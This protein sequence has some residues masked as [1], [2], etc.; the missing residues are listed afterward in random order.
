M[1][2]VSV[3]HR[4]KERTGSVRRGG[5][6]VA[7]EQYLVVTDDQNHAPLEVIDLANAFEEAEGNNVPR[8]GSLLSAI[9]GQARDAYVPL[10]NI[11]ARP[12]S[13]DPF[14]WRI[15]C[16][17]ETR[18]GGSGLQLVPRDPDPLQ[19]QFKYQ[20]DGTAERRVIEKTIDV[21]PRAIV[22]SA[23]QKFDPPPEEDEPIVTLFFER[24]EAFDRTVQANLFRNTVNDAA[25]SVLGF[26]AG[27][28]QARVQRMRSIYTL[29]RAGSTAQWDHYF[30]NSIEIWFREEGWDL[31][32]LDI[33]TQEQ[34]AH[35]LRPELRNIADDDGE[36]IRAPVPLDGQGRRLQQGR[37][38]V[39]LPFRVHTRRSFDLLEIPT[40]RP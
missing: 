12:A 34:I 5:I 6:R 40:Q 26:T 3:D 23:G 20:W 2:V 27:A 35:P 19:Q 28:G 11:D 39:F 16:T 13:E 31:D 25:W 22:N 38:P 18:S 9:T 29:G 1:A 21:P 14:T 7:T 36:P 8:E 17:F 37:R 10:D 24:N 4:F 32:L 33:G 15:I 30:V